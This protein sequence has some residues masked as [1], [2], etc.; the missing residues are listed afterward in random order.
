MGGGR[1][2]T[3]EQPTRDRTQEL[4]IPAV[5]PK[6]QAQYCAMCGRPV[7]PSHEKY[8]QYRYCSRACHEQA[9]IINNAENR[10]RKQVAP[11]LAEAAN[12]PE[13]VIERQ[14][15]IRCKEEKGKK[16]FSRDKSRARGLCNLC[17]ECEKE[18]FAA[19]YAAN[20]ERLKAKAK[21]AKRRT[22]ASEAPTQQVT[23][24]QSK[25]WLDRAKRNLAD[26]LH[27]IPEEGVMALEK[28]LYEG[29][30]NGAVF[31][32]KGGCGCLWGTIGRACGWSVSQEGAMAKKWRG[33]GCA[34]VEIFA[35]IAPGDLPRTN[36]YSKIA[37]EVIQSCR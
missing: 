17:R 33:R 28:A 9:R 24:S 31:E 14:T 29:R 12:M 32:D 34:E 8:A 6:K 21:E 18:K 27:N 20:K 2:M 37:M 25:G 35:R 16:D 10:K 15:C 22:R 11:I 7:G 19:Y 1:I 13:P 30:I 3:T 36:P 26:I 4:I 5:P 23:L